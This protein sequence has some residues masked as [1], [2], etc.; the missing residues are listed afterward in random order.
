LAEVGVTKASSETRSLMDSRNKPSSLTPRVSCTETALNLDNVLPNNPWPH[1]PQLSR[2][3]ISRLKTS[4][5]A[6]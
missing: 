1:I 4:P 6:K 3:E 5:A 2:K